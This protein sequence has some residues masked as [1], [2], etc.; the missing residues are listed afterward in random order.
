MSLAEG[1]RQAIW[2]VDKDQPISKVITMEEAAAESVT[3]RKVS[4]VLLATFAAL[5][6][7]LAMIGLYGVMAYLVAQRTHEIGVRMALGARPLDISQLVLRQGLRLAAVGIV[8]GIIAGLG[9]T[10]VMASLLFGV[11]PQDPTTFLAVAALLVGVA[12]AASYLP[13]LR[14]MKVDPMVA[15][16]YE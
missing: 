4:M 14:A 15:L 12:L 11:R 13:A 5:A 1:I 9:L 3:L 6:M 16:R 8:L 10:Q 2:S 7:F